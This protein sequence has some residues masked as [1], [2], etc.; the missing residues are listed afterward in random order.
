MTMTRRDFSL[1]GL[2][3]APSG[4]PAQYQIVDAQIHVWINDPRYPWAAGTK[5]LPAENRTPEMAL[6]L[7]KA[8]G[9]QRTVIAQY[10]GYRWDNRYA[11]DSIK[12]YTPYFMGVCRVDP[13][14]PAAPDQLSEL[15]EE[16]FHGVRISPAANASGEWINGPLMP[17]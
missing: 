11:L 5:N 4:P 17:P 12:K 13:T 14:D 16:G 3:M 10:I 9:V 15:T 8:N 7:M 1:A 6:E 2:A